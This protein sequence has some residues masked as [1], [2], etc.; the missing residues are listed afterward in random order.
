[1]APK[2]SVQMELLNKKYKAQLEEAIGDTKKG[3]AT[4]VSNL[5]RVEN[6]TSSM[7]G[8]AA[9]AHAVVAKALQSEAQEAA[10][11]AAVVETAEQAKARARNKTASDAI[12]ADTKLKN[13]EQQLINKKNADA[14]ATRR[15]QIAEEKHAIAK[16]KATGAA[17]RQSKA[18]LGL[19]KQLIMAV[20]GYAALEVTRLQDAWTKAEVQI[21]STTSSVREALGVQQQLYDQ[22]QTLGVSYTGLASN[23]GRF[24][25]SLAEYGASSDDVIQI[26]S[27]LQKAFMMEG[28]TANE[29]NS[30]IIQL[31]QSLRSGV[32][33]GDEFRSV[34]ESSGI[35]LKALSKEMNVNVGAL[36]KLASENKITT[37]NVLNAA[38]SIKVQDGAIEEMSNTWG[39]IGNKLVN[40][41]GKA[42]VAFD[43]MTGIL[44]LLK[45]SLTG[46]G[47]IL[48]EFGDQWDKFAEDRNKSFKTI[49]K[50]LGLLTPEME[51]YGTETER[52]AAVTEELTN[53]EKALIESKKKLAILQKI[54]ADPSAIAGLKVY[55]ATLEKELG[56]QKALKKTL[57]E[58]VEKNKPKDKKET[59]NQVESKSGNLAIDQSKKFAKAERDRLKGRIQLDEEATQAQIDNL[60][61]VLKQTDLTKNQRSEIEKQVESLEEWKANTKQRYRDIELEKEKTLNKERAK[62]ALERLD[63]ELRVEKEGE[64]SKL[65]TILANVILRKTIAKDALDKEV[66]D[67]EA[68]RKRID[69]IDANAKVLK[70]ELLKTKDELL[71]EK[72]AKELSDY[73]KLLG[74]KAALDFRYTAKKGELE[75][76]QV[77]TAGS[78]AVKQFRS[79]TG[80][81]SA[82]YKMSER[83][84]N[85][86]AQKSEKFAR[87]QFNIQKLQKGT[88]A[89]VNT[90][91]GVTA[92]LSHGNFPLAIATGIAGAAEIAAIASSQFGSGTSSSSTSSVSSSETD[93]EVPQ[94]TEVSLLNTSDNSRMRIDIGIEGLDTLIEGVALGTEQLKRDGRIG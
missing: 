43:K 36:K 51:M 84:M 71:T 80:L 47:L 74:D 42:I 26:T 70:A 11:T 17:K 41:L 57:N 76:Q 56:V 18:L 53:K 55:I 88:E 93:T 59:G 85:S 32:L 33:A 12:L 49:A 16:D 19:N 34:S 52:L 94:N 30:M 8:Q 3:Q 37:Q 2:I 62:D 24:K 5:K 65:D 73:E 61:K 58:K 60:K 54:S 82:T 28:S 15:L 25:R 38:K 66:L 22:A 1:M 9:K 27:N 83:A 20:A 14:N 40:S 4:I 23:F 46:W 86:F 13:A 48:D 10:K 77:D 79:K 72:Y 75:L 39:A 67:K 7:A 31:S 44:T 89:F 87:A 64:Q 35:F 92:A 50:A 63:E 90:R 29:T 68:Y 6:A 81:D 69:E 45:M 78:L 21:N 91:A